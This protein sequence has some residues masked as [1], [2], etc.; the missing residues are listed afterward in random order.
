MDQ[1][2]QEVSRVR[3]LLPEQVLSSIRRLIIAGVVTALV[4]SFVMFG[5]RG[6][7]FGGPSE[8]QTCVSLHLRPST[9][10]LIAI[11]AVGLGLLL[12]VLARVS[13]V[14]RA[15][16]LLERAVRGIVIGGIV[17][18]VAGHAWFWSIPLDG[19]SSGS[20]VFFNPLFLLAEITVD[21]QLPL[22]TG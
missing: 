20:Y 3:G 4:Y 21:V 5:S 10:F 11:A 12:H 15:E 9:F 8:P 2:I 7:C 18:V 22:I 17:A 6:Q 13:D 14:E 16:L 19:F 1:D